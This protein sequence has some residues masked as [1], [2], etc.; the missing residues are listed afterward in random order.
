MFT[1]EEARL[2]KNARTKRWR[3]ANP[4]KSKAAIKAWNE[5]NKDRL[6]IAYREW[7]ARNPG[8]EEARLLD[9]R[10]NN[11]A[12]YKETITK[13][14]ALNPGRVRAIIAR[15]RAQELHA[16]PSWLTSIQKAQIQEFYEVAAA[17]STQTG[18]LHEV[19]HVYPLRGK[20]ARG[21]HVPWN[22]QVLPKAINA[23]KGNR[24][25]NEG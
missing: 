18:E 7:K 14:R 8:V 16:T 21:L 4:E 24:L 23:S 17:L 25:P 3:E 20:T 5:R 13:W 22:L 15:R 11:A 10:L 2:R 12:K 6:R 1:T 19:D 9:Y